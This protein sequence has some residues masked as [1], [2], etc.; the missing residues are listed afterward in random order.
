MGLGVGSR[1]VNRV[2]LTVGLNIVGTLVVPSFG[3]E[4]CLAVGIVVGS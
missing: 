2:S 4:V 1:D 3:G